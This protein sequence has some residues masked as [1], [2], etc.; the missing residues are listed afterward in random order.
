[1]RKLSFFSEQV[2]LYSILMTLAVLILMFWAGFHLMDVSREN[3]VISQ[4][5]FTRST[6]EQV[7]YYLDHLRLIATQAAHDTVIV[8]TME[9]LSAVDHPLGE[10]YFETNED[11]R[12]SIDRILAAHNHVKDPVYRIELYN[13]AGDYIC[14]DFTMG[15][16]QKGAQFASDEQNRSFLQ[17]AFVRDAR[18]FIMMG[19]YLDLDYPDPACHDCVYMMIPIKNHEETE[20][21]GYVTVYQPIDA[22][23]NQLELDKR[24]GIEIYLYSERDQARGRQI[25]PTDQ[26]FPDT[27]SGNYYETELQSDYDW[28][29]VLLQNQGEFLAPYRNML[30]C[31]CISGAAL[32]MILLLCVYL[33][34]HYIN[35]PIMELSRK[36]RSISLDHVPNIQVAQQAT[37]E[38][39]QLEDSFD[40]MVQ[41]LK[42]SVELE[43]TAYL[44][45]LQAQM[46]PHFL[47]NCLSTICSMSVPPYH[48]QIPEFCTRLAAMLRYESTYKDQAGILADELKNAQDYL[49]LM[50][51]RYEEDFTYEMETD[52]RLIQLPMPRL[53]L[54]PILENCFEHGF[55]TMAPPWHIRIRIFLERQ[56]W[57]ITIADNG[58]G[59]DD[60]ARHTL[61]QQ[62]DSLMAH[63]G[64]NYSELKIGGMGLASTIVRLRL[65][66]NDRLYYSITPNNPTGTII[67]LKG[68][69]DDL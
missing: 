68:A 43:R 29:V 21:Y 9:A 28:F 27:S 35:R 12:T 61:Q 11:V 22:L 53:V 26:P 67:T 51:F 49:E 30:L 69:L 38:I 7:D 34:A 62:V 14:T 60:T 19:P 23:Y 58:N 36:V 66:S 44:N 56:Q 3:A 46:N 20:I 57:C 50:K 4:E 2:L 39:K 31:L 24:T 17:A 45:A 59:F 25:Y 63:F 47:Y 40:A 13:T 48:T 10:N 65:A 15:L 1:M 54:Q 52:E 16:L 42:A 37:N 32:L 18:A 8:H 41:H 55:R 64:E 33:L 6:L 5:Q